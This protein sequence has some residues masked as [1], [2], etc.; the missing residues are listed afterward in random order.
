MISPLQVACSCLCRFYNAE[1]LDLSCQSNAA[2]KQFGIQPEVIRNIGKHKMLPTHDSSL[3]QEMR[4]YKITTSDGVV[5]RKTQ[6]HLKPY[7]PQ[8][9]TLQSTHCV[10]QPI[11]QSDHIWPVKQLMAQSD[12]KKSSQVNN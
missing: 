6:A 3:C 9:K 12:H 5:C 7:A 10:S 4:S 11:A 2:R 1:M 8:N